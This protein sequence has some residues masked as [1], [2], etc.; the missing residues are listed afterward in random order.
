MCELNIKYVSFA[1]ETYHFIKSAACVMYEYD[2][3]VSMGDVY[4]HVVCV[5]MSCTKVWCHYGIPVFCVCDVWVEHKIRLFC[6]R[7]L[8]FNQ[9]CGV[10]TV[11]R[12]LVCVLY[13]FQKKSKNQWRYICMLCVCCVDVSTCVRYKLVKLIFLYWCVFKWSNLNVCIEKYVYWHLTDV[14]M[15]K[16]IE[17]AYGM[18]T[19]SK[20]DKMIGLFRKRDV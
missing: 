11:Y 10:T 15:R 20:I 12:H 1:K 17:Y 7:D 13:E 4:V 5:C 9:K 14:C 18:A 16:C 3:G 19:V 6:K 2:K 8:S